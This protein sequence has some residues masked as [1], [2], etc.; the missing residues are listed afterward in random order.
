VPRAAST[1]HFE[2][3]D[4]QQVARY[5]SLVAEVL[6]TPGIYRKRFRAK[7]GGSGKQ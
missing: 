4:T 7:R 3:F 5:A 2:P 6:T 1:L